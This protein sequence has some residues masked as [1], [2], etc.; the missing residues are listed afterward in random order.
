M[1]ER[2]RRFTQSGRNKYSKISVSNSDDYKRGGSILSLPL[3]LKCKNM[4]KKICEEAVKFGG[5]INLADC[6][7]GETTGASFIAR[8][9]RYYY[10]LAGFV[11]L[12]KCSRILEIGTNCGGSIMSMS[13]AL[14]EAKVRE[15]NL[16]TVDIASKNEEGFL[17][18]PFIKRIYGDSLEENVIK[19][20]AGVFDGEIDLLYIDSLHEYEH[21][22]K[23]IEIYSAK[24]KPKY[25]I[26]D[27]IRQTEGMKKLWS[28]LEEKFGCNA[29]DASDI[30]RRPGAGFGVIKLR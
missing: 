8:P 6:H 7:Y 2:G 16:V 28:E 23:N 29:F 24:L 25:V 5:K 12:E 13:R 22:K 20:A 1:R 21:T 17:K 30:A 11:F 14:D 26:L 9:T 27:D 19:K 10:F 3:F 4:L 18:Y 15:R